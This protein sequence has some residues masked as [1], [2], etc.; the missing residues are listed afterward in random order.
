VSAMMEANA[1]KKD[2][3][4]DV[5]G[6]DATP[7]TEHGA[8][9][10]HPS[11]LSPRPSPLASPDRAARQRAIRFLA[12]LRRAILPVAILLAA[13]WAAHA[14]SPSITATLEPSEIDLGEA[15]QLTVTIQSQ[16]D[17]APEIPAVSGLS[18]QPVGQSSQIQ[19]INGTMSANISH[20]YMV[21]ADRAGTF[22]VPKIKMGAG[23]NA[24][25]SQ[26]LVLKVLH[27]AGGH[28]S[29]VPPPS[30]GQ[31]LLP[32]P[33]PTVDDLPAAERDSFGFLRISSPKKEFY[34]GEM[35]PV[36]LK[37]CFRA[38]VDLRVDGLPR[39][40]SDAFTMNKL[41]DQ[42]ARSQQL[43]GGVPY[44][45]FTWQTA[46]TAVKAGDYQMSVEIPTTVTVRQRAQHPT[47]P[48]TGDPFFDDFFNDSFFEGFFGTATQKAVTLSSQP[49]PAK[50]LS[51]PTENRPADFAGAVG[52]FEFA[53]TATPTKSVVGDPITLKLRINGSGNFDRVTAPLLEKTDAWKTYKPNEKF[54]PEDS[55]GYSGAKTF[56]QALVPSQT[57]QLEIS[58]LAF[59]SFDPEKKQ[60]VTH[61]TVPI[62]IEVGPAPTANSSTPKAV[63][64]VAPPSPPLEE[65]VAERRL[66]AHAGFATVTSKLTSWLL[67]PWLLAWSVPPA[68]ALFALCYFIRRRQK[69]ARDPQRLRLQNTRLAVQAQLK[70]M[71]SAAMQGAAADFFAAAR[72]AFQNQLGLWWNL[73]PQTITLAEINTRMNGEAD[74]FRPILELAD[75]VSYTGRTFTPAEL[76]QWLTT[77]TIE[78][79]K[80]EP[81]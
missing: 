24:S 26:P 70:I 39:L 37:A 3:A 33:A 10:T 34:V 50:I 30:Q 27:R 9:S 22:T 20:T 15:A 47:R 19:I 41:S 64:A 2:N 45:V 11:P 21:T 57:G 79:E 29:T 25:E 35:I 56:E 46:L 44:T 1:M 78:L 55:V 49:T 7:N 66:L 54:E 4:N 61:T 63:A 8:R 76:Q 59:S 14:K 80:L 58:A 65:R 68:A 60:Y 74:S 31:N 67:T 12:R 6:R 40:N 32:G 75:E 62:S 73:P 71:E 13:V 36:E 42:P 69:L 53:A 52:N 28:A 23:A 72:C 43:I 77:A 16:E 48:R 17:A 38:G 5:S 81:A 51:L 18:F